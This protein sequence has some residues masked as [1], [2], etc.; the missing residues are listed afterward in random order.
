MKISLFFRWYDL[1]IGFYV[2]KETKTLYFC[3]IPMFGFKIKLP[4]RHYLIWGSH[5][6]EKPIGCCVDR[7]DVLVE[8]PG[9]RFTR[10]KKKCP[11]CGKGRWKT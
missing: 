3:P 6:K 4:R 1:W 9:S 11:I 2:D 10:V 7:K 5:Y 8:E